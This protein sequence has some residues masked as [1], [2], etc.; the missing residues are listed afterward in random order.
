MWIG[1]NTEEAQFYASN[2]SNPEI[3]GQIV[4]HNSRGSGVIYADS[5]NATPVPLPYSES[6]GIG[7]FERSMGYLRQTDRTNRFVLNE[8]S[9]NTYYMTTHINDYKDTYK[10]VKHI[11]EDTILDDNN[12]I[13]HYSL[14]NEISVVRIKLRYTYG[15]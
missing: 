11:I 8:R 15:R 7:Y 12:N 6:L 1:I 4:S 10:A 2:I 3:Y 14:P 5:T 9:F 13:V